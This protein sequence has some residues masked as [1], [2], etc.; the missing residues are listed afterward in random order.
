MQNE[1]QTAPDVVTILW[2]RNQN[3]SRTIVAATVIGSAHPCENCLQPGDRFSAARTCLLNNGFQRVFQ[4]MFG[5]FGVSVFVR[6]STNM[7]CQ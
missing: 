1:N 6:T 5:D 7:N 3:G 4:E 2:R